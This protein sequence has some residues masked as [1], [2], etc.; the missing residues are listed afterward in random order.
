MATSDGWRVEIVRRGRS[1]WYR[2]VHGDAV[3]DWL[4][5][6]TVQRILEEAGVDMANLAAVDEPTR[7]QRDR[8]T[9]AA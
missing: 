7:A 5:I 9:G 6:A 2:I 8:Q 1:R 3:F 4:T